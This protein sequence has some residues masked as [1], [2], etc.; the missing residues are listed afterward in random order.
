MKHKIKRLRLKD[1]DVVVLICDALITD[2]QAQSVRLRVQNAIRK[3]GKEAE[4]LVLTKDFRLSIL[5]TS[6]LPDREPPPPPPDRTY[7]IA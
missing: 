1:H 6:R 7:R 5:A 4:V 2:T 3:V